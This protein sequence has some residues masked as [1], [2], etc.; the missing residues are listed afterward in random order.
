MAAPSIGEAVVLRSFPFGEA[1]RVLHVYTAAS[2]RLEPFS[3]VELSL[4]RGRGELA[5]V[6][7]ASLVRSHDR[8]R[9]DS[10]R[11]QIGLVGLEAMLRLFTEEERNDRAFLALTRFLDALDVHEPPRGA[12]PALDPLVLSFQLKLLWLSG[13]LPHLGSCVECG[14]EDGLVAFDAAA[15]GAVC[16]DCDRGG[17]GLS[18]EGLRGL[19]GLLGAPIGDAPS[20]GLG[21]RAAREALAV[22]TSSYEHHGGFR[23]R[24]L[25]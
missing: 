1:D 15:G 17:I 24:T 21:D 13:F 25:A 3:H 23:L 6:T 16:A 10:R 14:A 20:L 18:S 12:R 19:A 11:L 4:H 8:I 7:G 22:V 5:T 9:S 2:G